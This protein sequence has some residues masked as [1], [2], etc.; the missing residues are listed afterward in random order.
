[1]HDLNWDL[2]AVKSWVVEALWV[3]GFP[4]LEVGKFVYPEWVCSLGEGVL[5]DSALD[6]D[7]LTTMIHTL[8]PSN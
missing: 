4:D 1:M 2:S 5:L 7:S 6:G 8:A 3:T